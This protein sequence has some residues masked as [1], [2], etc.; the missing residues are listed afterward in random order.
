MLQRETE[1]I[2]PGLLK[3]ISEKTAKRADFQGGR[4]VPLVFKRKDKRYKVLQV[5]AS[6]EDREG[7]QKLYFFSVTADS[8]DVYQLRLNGKDM[9]WYVDL[10]MMEG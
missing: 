9:T 1:Y 3:K 2:T 6:W 8:G 10:V 5:N 7:T 4:I